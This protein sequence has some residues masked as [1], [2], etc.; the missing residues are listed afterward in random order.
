M[1]AFVLTFRLFHHGK[2][3]GLTLREVAAAYGRLGVSDPLKAELQAIRE[4]VTR[5]L[6]GPTPLD[7]FGE[8]ITRDE[9]L[10]VWL[11]GELAHRNPEKQ[12]RLDEWQVGD[13]VR[14]IFQHEFESIVAGFLQAIFWVRNNNL[15]ALAE[16]D[17]RAS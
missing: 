11:Y 8:R 12:A 13:D 15:S 4:Q 17:G 10:N 14:P 16:L 6:A 5:Y 9:L 3:D 2:R 1:K 7:L